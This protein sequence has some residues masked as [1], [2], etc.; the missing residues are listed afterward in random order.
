MALIQSALC[1]PDLVECFIYP[2]HAPN[3]YKKFLVALKVKNFPKHVEYSESW[4]VKTGFSKKMNR[5]CVSCNIKCLGRRTALIQSALCSPDLGECF[6]YPEHV[7]N[8]YKIFLVAL[9]VK[10]VPKTRRIL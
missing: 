1:S 6:T 8:S 9:K 4:L 7:P 5:V 10:N 3:S 2:E